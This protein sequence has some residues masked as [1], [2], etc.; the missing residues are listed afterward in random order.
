M[1]ENKFELGAVVR[2]MREKKSLWLAAAA[3]A[4]GIF[5]LLFGSSQESRAVSASPDS[6]YTEGQTGEYEQELE[7]RVKNLL[8]RVSGVSNVSV[9]I[10]L[11]SLSEQ[12]YAR[13]YRSSESDG[14][15]DI[16]LEY[17][18]GQDG[19]VPTKEL[20]PSVRGVAVVCSGGDDAAVALKVTRLLSSLFGIPTSSISVAGAKN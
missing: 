2:Y 9:M 6:R 19:L 13:N 20:S 14:S 5:L 17:V 11:E 8:E 10:T 3:L 16:G 1:S 7:T 12:V 18:N 15:T 4:I